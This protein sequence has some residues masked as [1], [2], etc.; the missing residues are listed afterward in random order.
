M[1]SADGFYEVGKKAAA[2]GDDLTP[3]VVMYPQ[4]VGASPL[5]CIVV[6][7]GG[8]GARLVPPLMQMLR[9]GDRLAI[10]DNDVVEDRN[11]LRQH[12]S[13]SDV[14]SPKALVLAERY[15][16]EG[17]GTGAI[18]A[19]L[20]DGNKASILSLC[21]QAAA[22]EGLRSPTHAVIFGCVDGSAG[23][24]ALHSALDMAGKNYATQLAWID[25]GNDMRSGQAMLSLR[26]WGMA[27]VAAKYPVP[28]VLGPHVCM[29]DGL[30]E[31]MP[32]LLRTSEEEKKE[33]SCADRVDIQTVQVN[34]MAASC[35]L[36]IFSS[37]LLGLPIQNAGVFF[38]T[39]N[40]LQPIKLEGY[41]PERGKAV[42]TTQ[43][44]A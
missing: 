16:R 10:M 23:R 21:I 32:Q 14:G 31:A 41:D 3:P 25:I 29:L 24:R 38:N 30:A 1:A 22:G 17:I 20:D 18:Q 19:M 4:A 43:F 26:R 6:G 12:F 28:K 34:V 35:A 44:A 15:R 7:A 11:L 33:A 27:K 13:R 5:L 36:N 42:P 2:G 37:L 9:P 39:G 40:A 8:N